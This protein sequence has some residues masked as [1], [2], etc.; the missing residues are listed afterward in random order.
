MPKPLIAGA[1]G[2][3]GC[4]DGVV[5]LGPGDGGEVVAFGGK[6][7]EVVGAGVLAGAVVGPVVGA[8]P[9]ESE[10]VTRV[11]LLLQHSV[12]RLSNTCGGARF[13]STLMIIAP[14]HANVSDAHSHRTGADLQQREPSI[15][16]IFINRRQC[17]CR[18]SFAR[19][20]A[21]MWLLNVF[22]P[23]CHSSLH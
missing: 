4:C 5:G 18:V 12:W 8:P 15:E 14:R 10:H 21:E 20:A 16:F 7:A 11:T 6:G 23:C 1:P 17:Q 3:A 13:H 2:G 22:V 19:H 9:P